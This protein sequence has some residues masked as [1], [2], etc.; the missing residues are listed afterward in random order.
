MPKEFDRGWH[1]QVCHREWVFWWYGSRPDHL[2]DEPLEVCSH[3]EP[4]ALFVY[5]PEPV[6]T[7]T[8]PFE[9]PKPHP[10][11]KLPPPVELG[12][13]VSWGWRIRSNELIHD[14]GWHMAD[15]KEDC[16]AKA[17]AYLARKEAKRD[18]ARDEMTDLFEQSVNDVREYDG[19]IW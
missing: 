18:R 5:E 2:K 13:K 6:G 1:L 11:S 16:V 3:I 9:L 12:R 8:L 15:S 19:G 4:A 7:I 17:K 14:C 10:G